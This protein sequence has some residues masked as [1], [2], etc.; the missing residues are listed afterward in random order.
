MQKEENSTREANEWRQGDRLTKVQ[1]EYVCPD[2]GRI[3]PIM[4]HRAVFRRLFMP[5]RQINMTSRILNCWVRRYIAYWTSRQDGIL[6]AE[7]PCRVS[8]MM[9]SDMSLPTAERAPEAT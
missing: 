4:M 5:Q 6:S 9:T 8:S 2:D 1:V 3:M 7:T